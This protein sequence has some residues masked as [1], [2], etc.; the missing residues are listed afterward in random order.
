MHICYKAIKFNGLLSILLLAANLSDAQN[1]TRNDAQYTYHIKKISSPVIIDGKD[2]EAAWLTADSATQFKQTFP[3]DTSFALGQTTFK[4]CFDDKQLYVYAR[5]IQPNSFIVPSLKRDYPINS[6][7]QITII[8]DPFRDKLNGFYFAVNPYAIQKEGLIFNGNDLNADWDNKW[9]SASSIDSNAY[10]V[11]LAIPF[12][13]LRYKLATDGNNEWNFNL[14]RNNLKQIERSAWTSVPRNF[15]MLDLNF[16]G[17]LIWDDPP[18]PPGLNVSFIPYGTIQYNEDNLSNEIFREVQA[19]FDAKL[20]I[21]PSLNLDITVNPDFAQVEVDRQVTNLSRFELFFPER[22][23]FFLE[24]NDLFG[25]F[26]YDNVNPFFSR[27]IGLGKNVNNGQNVRVP[28]LAGTRLSGRI[29][30]TGGWVFSI[31]RQDEVTNSNY[32]PPTSLWRQYK[33][34]LDFVTTWVLYL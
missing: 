32:P 28:I 25:S 7:D 5:C 13:T 18:P 26:G 19:G 15:R 30:K 11:E 20:A 23:Q 22:R 14:L 31:C 24:N 33:D 8:L 3:Y 10:Q 21:T 2:D 17:K 6:S 34:E 9:Y 12:K 27:R 1:K 4:L 16:A 29:D